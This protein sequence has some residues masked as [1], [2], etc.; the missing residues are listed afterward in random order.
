MMKSPALLVLC[1]V[2]TLG[3][4][5]PA[6]AQ[7][8]DGPRYPLFTT[9]ATNVNARTGVPGSMACPEHPSP[10]NCPTV[11][12]QSQPGDQLAVVC[13]T[14]GEHVGTN[15]NWVFAENRTRGFEGFMASY[16]I[17]HPDDWL[18]GVPQCYGP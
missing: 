4:L 14:R 15:P 5:A 16:Y 2:A 18:P 13:Q 6:P 10:A 17:K 7:A 12:G 11:R 1:A 3:A 8:A 9:W